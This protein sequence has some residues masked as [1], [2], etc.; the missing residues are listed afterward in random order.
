[1]DLI[2]ERWEEWIG[3]M[4]LKITYPVLEGHEWR[5]VTGFDPKNTRRSYHNGGSFGQVSVGV[6]LRYF[7]F[8][9]EMNKRKK[10][11]VRTLGLLTQLTPTV[12]RSG[13]QFKKAVL[14]LSCSDLTAFSGIPI[15]IVCKFLTLQIIGKA[16]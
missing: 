6:R 10:M 4:P 5:I 7:F 15:K 14:A 8:T 16:I 2:E 3:G 12:S 13:F 9:G 11:L 1:M